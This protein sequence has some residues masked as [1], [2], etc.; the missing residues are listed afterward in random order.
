MRS[1]YFFIILCTCLFFLSINSNV[2]AETFEDIGCS[3]GEGEALQIQCDRLEIKSRLFLESQPVDV[4]GTWISASSKSK[5]AIVQSGNSLTGILFGSIPLALE[6]TITGNTLKIYCIQTAESIQKDNPDAPAS[7]CQAVAGIR[8]YYEL[9]VNNDLIS[10]DGFYNSYWAKYNTS[11]HK[12]TAKYDGGTPETISKWGKKP[13]TFVLEGGSI[14]GVAAWT[15]LAAD[16]PYF[17]DGNSY[18]AE[19]VDAASGAQYMQKQLLNVKGAIPISFE[20]SYNS[21]LTKEGPLG[22]GW[23]HNL[24]THLENIGNGTIVVHWNANR[25]NTYA[26]TGNGQF[27]SQDHACLFDKLIKNQD[28]TFTL[29]RKDQSVY[30][31]HSSGKLI[32][33]YNSHGQKLVLSHD[34]N[35]RLINILEPISG[36][37][38]DL[39]YNAN[40]L[41]QTVQDNSNRQVILTY[42]SSYHMIC[43][44]DALGNKT[45]Y[46]YNVSNGRITSA[47]DN[48]GNQLFSNTFDSWGRIDAQH[49]AVPDHIAGTFTYDETIRPGKIVT[50]Y[51]NRNG[52]SS[53]LIHDRNY[54]LLS[55]TDELGNT[56]TYTYDYNGNRTS[57]S[58]AKGN[59]TNYTY[60]DKGNLL[61]VTDPAGNITTMNYDGHNNLLTIT[62][63]AGKTTS[64]TYD[65]NNNQTSITDPEGNT[66]FFTYDENSLL[67]TETKPGGGKKTYSYENGLLKTTTDPNGITTSYAY[68][69]AGH[70]VS[71]SDGENHSTTMTYDYADNLLSITDPLGNTVSYTYDSHGNKLTQTDA[72]GNT[73]RYVYNENGKLI[74]Q[75]DALNNEITFEYDG[76]DRLIK[77]VDARGNA[78]TYTYDDAGKLIGTTNALGKTS[79]VQY[80]QVGNR[81]SLKDAS[82]KTISSKT[83]NSLN[84]PLTI[85]DALG[86]SISQAYDALGRITEITDPKSR[87]TRYSYDDLNR[88]VSVTDTMEGISQQSFDV[89]NN[90][91]SLTDPN[92]NQTSFSYDQGGRLNNQTTAGNTVSYSYNSIGLLA[93]KTNGRNQDANYQYDAADRI[94]SFTDTEGNVSYTYD[95]NGNVLTI[96]DSIGTI[97]REYDA[98][99]RVKKYTDTSG[100]VIQYTY[101]AAGNLTQLTYPDGKSVHYEY[102]AANQL[103]KVTDWSSR[104]TNYEY[105]DNG[106]L[107]KTARPNGS[108]QTLTYDDN[109][110]LLQQKDIDKDANIIAQYDFTYDQAG[111]VLTETSSVEPQ[112]F[113]VSDTTMTYSNGNRLATFN[114]EKVEYDADGNMTLGP[115][116]STMGAYTFDSRNR[117]IDVG[118]TEYAYDAMNNRIG[119]NDNGSP[120][121][122]VINPIPTLSQILVQSSAGKQTYYVYGLGLIGEE[123]AGVYSTY[124]YDRRGSTIALTSI[125]G[126]TTDKFSYGPYGELV[127]RTGTTATPFLYNGRDGV[128][129]DCNGLYYM[130]ARYYN[131]GIKRFIN[132]DALL[133][134]IN[135]GQSINR[136]AYVNGKPINMVD[137]WGLNA[138][139]DIYEV[140]LEDYVEGI[141]SFDQQM[142]TLVGDDSSLYINTLSVL[143]KSLN[144]IKQNSKLTLEVLNP[145][146]IGKV[147]SRI[148]MDR[149]N[150]DPAIKAE[151]QKLIDSGYDIA[152]SVYDI[153]NAYKSMTEMSGLIKDFNKTNITLKKVK[154]NKGL[155]SIYG[156]RNEINKAGMKGVMKNTM[157]EF[158]QKLFEGMSGNT[159]K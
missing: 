11:T 81:I 4:S 43:I 97:N 108:V 96:T 80:D 17:R 111:N 112:P 49:D 125:D 16:D 144:G 101:D 53:T 76:E 146:N 148:S 15:Q 23:G 86:N 8:S 22:I 36:K 19:P 20:I 9:T 32:E 137:P 159:Y 60:D 14:S 155:E 52:K 103:V 131:P 34:D 120:V 89:D 116:G 129:T 128:M 31:F 12:I 38:I 140:Y 71:T 70:L 91:T 114:G 68:D 100:N 87:V 88:L 58:D 28:N 95:A 13:A 145:F 37:Y 85:T 54:K 84:Q 51:T 127:N 106:R 93:K 59:T 77:S 83:Y 153:R 10:A 143:G 55:K 57:I 124:H 74:S 79:A 156:P 63:P 48:G 69:G 72:N 92:N 104:N 7:V 45:T 64:Y 158:F 133:G 117:L 150:Y 24:E 118:N 138:I 132:Q 152:S 121:S 157:A 30:N 99:N 130:R 115:I 142:N 102:D 110:Q 1:N 151:S 39:Q 46:T 75:I 139:D 94:S 62:N 47:K 29:T 135:N 126:K 25:Q 42:D 113:K 122:Y 56:T 67:L 147:V 18:I 44:I 109:G 134:E 21:L 2:Q 65:S 5:M 66:T 105:D 61:T 154:G 6:G 73:T 27:V 123:T 90:K 35:G 3:T 141:M 107:I 41:V 149:M 33:Q 50:T 98:L 119:T 78:T 40:G 26:D 136:F 82:G